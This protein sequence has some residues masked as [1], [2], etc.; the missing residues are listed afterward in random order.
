MDLLC[1]MISAEKLVK[2]K[3]S[4]SPDVDTVKI[5]C[6]NNKII[7]NETMKNQYE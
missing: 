2:N 1:I 6:E 4:R 5:S 3:K 7:G